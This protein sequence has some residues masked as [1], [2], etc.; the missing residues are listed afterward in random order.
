MTEKKRTTLP[1]YMRVLSD[2]QAPAQATLPG[3]A[4]APEVQAD[5]VDGLTEEEQTVW[6]ELV[7]EAPAD[8]VA[9]LHKPTMETLVRAVMMHRE[10]ST[11]VAKYGIV[12]K[13]PSGYPIQSPYVSIANKAASAILKISGELG[14]TYGSRIRAKTGGKS[15]KPGRNSFSDLK[16]IP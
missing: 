4:P 1:A 14:L 7:A 8:V 11:Q 2:P 16:Q 13:S 9:N 6:D 15:A 10:A 3:V 5:K 12:I